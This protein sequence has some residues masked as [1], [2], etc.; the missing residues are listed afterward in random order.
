MASPKGPGW[1]SEWEKGGH[2]CFLPSCLVTVRVHNRERPGFHLCSCN[3]ESMELPSASLQV[4]G[5]FM[6]GF[7]PPDLFKGTLKR[8][9][10]M[11]GM[12]VCFAR[13]ARGVIPARPKWLR[14][15]LKNQS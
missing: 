6:V 10:G 14:S 13:P 2:L 12:L 15:L 8:E 1:Q 11:A 9:E 5:P 3:T 4:C 7:L